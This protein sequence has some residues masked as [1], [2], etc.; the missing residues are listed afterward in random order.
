MLRLD[1]TN[2]CTIFA[3]STVV[4]KKREWKLLAFR[5]TVKKTVRRTTTIISSLSLTLFF[6]LDDS[7]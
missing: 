4:N 7:I 5:T 6:G 1:G 3:N 2:L